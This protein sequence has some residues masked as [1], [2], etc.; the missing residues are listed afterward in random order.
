MTYVQSY[1]VSQILLSILTGLFLLI[2]LS[3]ILILWQDKSE[4]KWRNGWFA[5]MYLF[6]FCLCLAR[7]LRLPL[8]YAAISYFLLL[9]VLVPCVWCDWRNFVLFVQGK[10]RERIEIE[11]G[12]QKM[13]LV[14]LAQD[15][16]NIKLDASPTA[17]ERN[18]M[19]EVPGNA[20]KV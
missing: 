20:E 18:A 3:R 8:M 6:L 9:I 10:N 19:A 12:Q 11:V 13:T 4:R 17:V 2:L 5:S 16:V 1:F 14:N 7:A 15:H